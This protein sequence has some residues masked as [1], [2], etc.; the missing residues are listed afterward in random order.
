M[1]QVAPY[2][3]TQRYHAGSTFVEGG[4]RSQVRSSSM[5]NLSGND[6]GDLQVP[7]GDVSNGLHNALDFLL[8]VDKLKDVKRRNPLVGGRRRERTAEHC[9]HLAMAV[10][11]LHE[12][13][14]E[15][16]NVERAI[17]LS[18]VHDLPEAAVGDTF[19]YGRGNDG[20][21]AR[22]ERA[23]H[24]MVKNL[25]APLGELILDDW[26]EYEYEKSA[27]GRF[28]MALD[29]L[30]PVFMNLAAG[31]DSSWYKYEVRAA[32]VRARVKRV[33]GVVPELARMAFDAVDEGVRQHLLS[34]QES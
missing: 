5:P 16:L 32:D 15:P 23:L 13:A 11:C 8:A 9:W 25:A 4:T 21:R 7:R 19:V 26:T 18:I 30:L 17:R 31:R 6:K 29:V 24:A 28:V 10:L 2:W 34:D 1:Q 27:E 22:E 20:R 3:V 14:T 12:F 33:S